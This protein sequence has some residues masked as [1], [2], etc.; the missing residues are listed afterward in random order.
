MAA[1]TWEVEWPRRL[2][3]LRLREEE[4]AWAYFFDALRVEAK[5]AFHE[6]LEIAT[7]GGPWMA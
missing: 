3:W 4:L 7:L 1:G 6:L 5:E 2:D